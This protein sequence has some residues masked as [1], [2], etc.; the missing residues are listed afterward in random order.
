MKTRVRFFVS[1]GMLVFALVMATINNWTTDRALLFMA[2]VFSFGG[3]LL[4]MNIGDSQ[5]F[6][7]FSNISLSM[8]AFMM[9]HLI[10]AAGFTYR[11]DDV[12]KIENIYIGYTLGLATFCILVFGTVYKISMLGNTV[13]KGFAILCMIYSVVVGYNMI[14]IFVYS[15]TTNE[16]LFFLP[17]IGIVLFFLSDCLIAIKE[18]LQ[19]SSDRMETWIWIL[20]V[21]GQMMILIG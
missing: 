11:L 20:Y 10:Y 17:P 2:M 7:N 4:R 5:R 9:A 3:D 18:L 1:L 6:W 8:F 21:S 13:N 16:K 19:I 15:V 14:K 12:G